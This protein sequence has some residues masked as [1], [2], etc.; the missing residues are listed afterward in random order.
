MNSGQLETIPQTANETIKTNGDETPNSSFANAYDPPD[1]AP[2][3]PRIVLSGDLK[4]TGETSTSTEEN[5][6]LK[7]KIGDDANVDWKK[8]GN[9]AFSS[10]DYHKAIEFYT[11]GIEFDPSNA[12]LFSNR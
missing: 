6:V 9:E 12:A 11:N 10:G 2:A 7:D 3:G 5:H 1:Y 8:K 4:Q